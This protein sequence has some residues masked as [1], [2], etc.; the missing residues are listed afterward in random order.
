MGLEI[1]GW[2][3]AVAS[4][5]VGSDWPQGDETALWRLG[6]AWSGAADRIEA[7]AAA[8]GY[9]LQTVLASID[10]RAGDSLS[11]YWS[12]AGGVADVFE[13]L[14]SAAAELGQSCTD[15]GTD[16]EYTKLSI[17]AALGALAL[18]IAAM[19]AAA[20]PTLG[21]STAGIVAAEV[22]TTLT[23]RM[24]LQQLLIRVIE[25]AAVEAA[26]AVFSGLAIQ[27]GQMTMDHRQS[28]DG[29]KVVTEGRDGFIKGLANGGLK[30]TPDRVGPD[31]NPLP[32]G[33]RLQQIARGAFDDAVS[34]ASAAIVTKEVTG[35]DASLTDITSGAIGGGI[36][37][38]K[39]GLVA[40][41]EDL[42]AAG[43][44]PTALNW[45]F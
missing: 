2:L 14:S 43:L 4:V 34:G 17:L 13:R 5:A 8:G 11:R 31:P 30:T 7:S 36:G 27:L 16:I 12:E 39:D 10:G 41:N 15:T 22:A 32:T 23:V 45:D 1:P 29:G 26:A 44:S 35:G 28:I 40:R 3:Q 18:E 21:A 20:V 25:A 42:N 9:G 33:S 38:V 37:S 24:L 6:D 19:V